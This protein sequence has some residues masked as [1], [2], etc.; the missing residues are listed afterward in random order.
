MHQ[1][2]I[3]FDATDQ[4]SQGARTWHQDHYVQSLPDETIN[5]PEE[6]KALSNIQ[7]MPSEMSLPS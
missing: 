5:S 4:K 6:F 2:V 7:S 1:E 3:T